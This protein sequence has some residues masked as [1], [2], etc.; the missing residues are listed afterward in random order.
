[1]LYFFS[2]WVVYPGDRSSHPVLIRLRPFQV[3]VFINHADGTEGNSSAIEVEWRCHMVTTGLLAEPTVDTTS[4][5]AESAPLSMALETI[6]S[7]LK[8]ASASL[9]SLKGDPLPTL[10]LNNFQILS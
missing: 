4:S 8:F 3:K 2:G 6:N 10:A 7:G 9:K 1:M 5:F